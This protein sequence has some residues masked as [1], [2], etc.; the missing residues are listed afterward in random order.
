[1]AVQVRPAVGR[2]DDFSEVVGVKK[3]GGR[4]CWCMSY[5]DSRVPE[6]ERAQYMRDECAQEPGPG[7]LAY[8]DGVVAG[9][10]SVAPRSSYRRLMHS[11]TIP[12]LDDRDAWSIVCFVVRAGFRR[13]G[14]MHQL[15]AG[16]VEHA[17]E[18]GADVV[19]GYPVV[20]PQDD[21]VD[22]VSGYV[23]TTR[24]FEAGGFV[25][26]SA[27]SAHS[28]GRDRVVMRRELH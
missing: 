2:Y 18:Q 26:V 9:W 6:D 13:R 19:E 17:R 12:F 14:L 4:G 7:V 10:C 1:M 25:Q 3:P 11:R 24:L 21:R 15:L 22:V 16:A 20:V 28:G 23:G 27:T 8:V 5:R